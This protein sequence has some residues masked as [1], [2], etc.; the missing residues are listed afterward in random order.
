M[1]ILGALFG[2]NLETDLLTLLANWLLAWLK[3]LL[4]GAL[5]LST[6]S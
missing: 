5:G 3:D 4:F 6:A 1:N 2:S